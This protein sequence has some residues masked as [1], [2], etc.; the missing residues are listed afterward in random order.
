M[1]KTASPDSTIHEIA[2]DINLPLSGDSNKICV[3]GLTYHTIHTVACQHMHQVHSCASHCTQVTAKDEGVNVAYLFT[4]HPA[5]SK[6][7]LTPTLTQITVY[8]YSLANLFSTST[9]T[10]HSLKHTP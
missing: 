2:S 9:H 5:P 3:T 8:L 7:H 6:H 1:K 10:H 4:T